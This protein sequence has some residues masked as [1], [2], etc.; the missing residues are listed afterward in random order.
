MTAR[1]CIIDHAAGDEVSLGQRV[2]VLA[3]KGE[4]PK[5]VVESLGLGQ[6]AAGGRR[7][8]RR[9]PAATAA[10]AAAPSHSG[11]QWPA[12]AGSRRGTNRRAGRLKA[13]PLA[14]KVAASSQ[15]ELGQVRG[16]GPGGRIV[17]RDVEAFLQGRAQGAAGRGGS[18]DQAGRGSGSAAS[19]PRCR[20]VGRRS[21]RRSASRTRGCARRSPS[22]CCRPSRPLPRFT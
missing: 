18:R 15:V 16:S 21:G 13:S 2:M 4:D 17:R 12:G 3:K 8:G 19:R 11:G 5:K 7:Q 10:A 14:R 1:S 6:G 22:A 9:Q 20:G